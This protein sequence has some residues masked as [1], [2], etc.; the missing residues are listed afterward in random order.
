[1][2]LG[3]YNVT[4]ATWPETA[5]FLISCMMVAG[6]KIHNSIMVSYLGKILIWELNSQGFK[7]FFLKSVIKDFGFFHGGKRQYDGSLSMIS[8]LRKMLVWCEVSK[9][10]VYGHFLGSLSL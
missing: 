1:M 9:I 4:K 7:L 10:G 3:Y 2:K 5:K 6:N 8:Y